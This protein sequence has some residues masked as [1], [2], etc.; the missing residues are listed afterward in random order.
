MKTNIHGP[1]LGAVNV[2]LT[3][4]RPL[5]PLV[6]T[7]LFSQMLTMLT[8]NLEI[9]RAPPTIFTGQKDSKI[10]ILCDRKSANLVY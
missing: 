4:Q 6:Q 10:D 1:N 7:A 2:P 9:C 3:P 8:L 5:P